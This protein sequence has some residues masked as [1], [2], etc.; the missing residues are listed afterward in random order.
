M[1]LSG[2]L[3][4]KKSTLGILSVLPAA[5]ILILYKGYPLIV[6]FYESLRNW[7]GLY[8]NRFIGFKN[9]INIITNGELLTM[10]GNNL[11]LLIHVPLLIFGGLIFALLLY[12]ECIGWKIFRSIAY[13]PNVISIAIVGYIF[14]RLFGPDG[15]VYVVLG[16]MGI[17]IDWLAHG[18]SGMAVVVSAVL[19]QSLGW[20]TILIFG[21]LTSIS[22]SVFE[23]AKIDGAGYWQ[24]LFKIVLPSI[25]PVLEYTSILSV[26]MVFGSSF[27]Y[28]FTIT[29]GGPGYQTTTMDYMIYAKAFGTG[30]QMGFACAVG[31]FL[32]VIILIAS[33]VQMRI[34]RMTESEAE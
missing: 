10:L 25:V 34:A 28:I 9:F 33:L 17:H 23:A 16:T 14:R 27:G 18:L 20:E 22:P 13:L 15:P 5:L 1:R 19:W 31:V 8:L 29:G 2:H 12:E 11:L 4:M 7:D 30:T 6:T 3:K 24:R 21:G 26:I 32:F